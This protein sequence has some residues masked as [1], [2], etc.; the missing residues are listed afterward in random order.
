MGARLAEEKAD[1]G[2]RS[3]RPTEIGV[4]EISGL[5]LF[6]SIRIFPRNGIPGEL[7]IFKNEAVRLLGGSAG[8][9][10]IASVFAMD[11]A[12]VEKRRGISKNEI[13]SALDVTINKIKTS[14]VDHQGV[15]PT[16]EAAIAE[17]HAVGVG[18]QCQGLTVIAGG[19]AEG[20]AT[21]MKVIAQNFDPGIE[22]IGVIRAWIMDVTIPYY[23][24]GFWRYSHH[25]ERVLALTDH[26]W[27]LVNTG[28]QFHHDGF[29]SGGVDLGQCLLRCSEW[30]ASITGNE[31]NFF[32][33]HGLKN[34]DE[35]SDECA[36]FSC[37][38]DHDIL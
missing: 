5:S 23:D 31:E 25:A 34:H 32:S 11:M 33:I 12:S 4:G 19:I 10:D 26:Q 22:M 14:F 27:S 2:I 9:S 24:R 38:I 17:F 20:D 29:R 8:S 1:A 37:E 36:G 13:D 30:C 35:Q 28:G 6:G 16:F 21:C 7:A 18:S 3:P 15:L